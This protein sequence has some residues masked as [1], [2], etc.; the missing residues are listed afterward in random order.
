MT[1]EEQLRAS[2]QRR[3]EYAQGLLAEA[4]VAMAILETNDPVKA[5]GLVAQHRGVTLPISG[6]IGDCVR[7]QLE[8]TRDTLNY[9]IDTQED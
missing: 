3:L 5:K 7:K 1:T 9:Y 8:H 4:I 6:S 2:A